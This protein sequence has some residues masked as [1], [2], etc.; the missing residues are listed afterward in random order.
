[1]SSADDIADKCIIIQLA[2]EKEDYGTVEDAALA[3]LS[4]ARRQKAQSSGRSTEADS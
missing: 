3:I 1:M 2:L 4:A